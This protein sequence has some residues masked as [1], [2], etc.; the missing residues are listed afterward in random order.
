MGWIRDVSVL[1]MLF[2]G[3]YL[4]RDGARFNH[5]MVTFVTYELILFASKIFFQRSS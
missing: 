3:V 4:A 2:N 1:R 5:E